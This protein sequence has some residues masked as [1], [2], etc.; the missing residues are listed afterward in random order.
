MIK[1]FDL[2]ETTHARTHTDTRFPPGGIRPTY[3]II[4]RLKFSSIKSLCI[5]QP[6]EPLTIVLHNSPL[7]RLCYF[8]ITAFIITKSYWKSV[9]TRIEKVRL[10]ADVL[11]KIRVTLFSLTIYYKGHMPPPDCCLKTN[12]PVLNASFVSAT[13]SETFTTKMSFSTFCLKLS[14]NEACFH[15]LIPEHRSPCPVILWITC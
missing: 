4:R 13:I 10:N 2:L 9:K 15:C 14:T 12:C 3:A 5:Q 6:F 1:I 7:T 11:F 8:Y